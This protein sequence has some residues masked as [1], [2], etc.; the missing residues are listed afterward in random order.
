MILEASRQHNQAI[1]NSRSHDFALAFQVGLQKKKCKH[2]GSTTY[3]DERYY[4][5]NPK[6]APE[7]FK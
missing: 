3:S 4:A 7:W 6:L 2:C 1:Q 5:E